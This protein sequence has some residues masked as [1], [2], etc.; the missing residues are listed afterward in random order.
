ML[1]FWIIFF[2]IQISTNPNDKSVVVDLECKTSD[3]RRILIE[4][5]KRRQ[6]F[7]RERTL[8]YATWPIQKQ[9]IKGKWDYNFSS[10]YLI[11]LLDFA[12]DSDKSHEIVRT[13][14]IADIKTHE[15][16][17]D[18]LILF[19]LELSRFR[20]EEHQCHTLEDKWFFAFKNLHKL[21]E[22]PVEF[23]E[24]E[25]QTLFQ[26]TDRTILDSNERIQMDE[27]ETEYFNMKN[28]LDYAIK[29]GKAEGL[30]EGIAI[31]EARGEAR[32]K[33]E[34]AKEMFVEKLPLSLIQKITGI[35][36]EELEKLAKN[37]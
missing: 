34:I 3:G 23:N 2:T 36:S 1:T 24:P 30:S 7:F 12:L 33:L 15:I 14:M 25:F 5:Q 28:A 29:T 9:G 20:K 11:S 37:L 26:I 21:K 17:T 6:E 13:K 16:W 19:N 4:L 32:G 31:G 35:D 8:Y 27:S 18:K 22:R 10:V